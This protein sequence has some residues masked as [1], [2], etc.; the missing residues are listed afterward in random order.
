MN[1]I[2]LVNHHRLILIYHLISIHFLLFGELPGLLLFTSVLIFSRKP[3]KHENYQA[4]IEYSIRVSH[5]LLQLCSLFLSY[6]ESMTISP[7][8]Y[9]RRKP[10][11]RVHSNRSQISFL[12]SSLENPLNA[13]PNLLTTS[14]LE[15]TLCIVP[16]LK[17]FLN[18]LLSLSLE[19][20][21]CLMP[22]WET[23]VRVVL[24]LLI[25]LSLIIHISI[26]VSIP[27]IAF[28]KITVKEPND[29]AGYAR[30]MLNMVE[31]VSPERQEG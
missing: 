29:W 16:S 4:L 26:L 27:L 20:L 1:C 2:S 17:R 23:V 7:M 9:I 5:H 8:E 28:V 19:S 13:I 18:M 12:Y 14:S 21:T 15:K 31:T 25:T 11:L 22:P 10:S 24:I 30:M 3:L 6:L